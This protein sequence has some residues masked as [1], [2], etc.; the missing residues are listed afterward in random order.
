MKEVAP[1]KECSDR[2]TACHGSC[3]KYQEWLNRYHAQQKHLEEGKTRWG[4][5]MNLS[6][7]KPYYSRGGKYEQ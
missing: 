7:P 5:G 3:E 2:H 1:C 6:R 4:Y